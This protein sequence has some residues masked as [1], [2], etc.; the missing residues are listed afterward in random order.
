MLS[1]NRQ[2]AAV[3]SNQGG[4][5]ITRTA[6]LLWSGGVG[7]AGYTWVPWKLQGTQVKEAVSGDWDVGSDSRNP[8]RQGEGSGYLSFS[9]YTLLEESIQQLLR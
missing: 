7:E 2:E 9:H 8:L 3:C 5:D 4:A 6:G 1:L